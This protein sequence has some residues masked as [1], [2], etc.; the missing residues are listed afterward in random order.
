[1]NTLAHVIQIN[2][3]RTALARNIF[4]LSIKTAIDYIGSLFGLVIA[5]PLYLFLIYKVRKDG[6]PAFY[7][8][9][10][11][12]KDGKA[13]KCW[14]FR[15]MRVDSQEILAELLANDPK[16]REEYQQTFKLKN[17]PRITKIGHILRKYSLDEL[18]QLWN[19]LR[20]EMSLIGPR[21]V[22]EDERKHYGALWSD[23]LSVKP[24]LTGLWQVSGRNDVSYAQRVEMDS[25]YVRN[26]SL[27]RDI[28]ILFKTF[29]VV[30]NGRG[31]Y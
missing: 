16:A 25:D 28:I 12:G 20:G 31:A 9:T 5:S 27:M 6:G 11:I 19:V 18:P 22:V 21:P 30:L 10:R 29:S 17:D 15:S 1:M 14:K 24:G 13:F 26:W 8:Q 3:Q 4:G 7:S 2:K 23:Y